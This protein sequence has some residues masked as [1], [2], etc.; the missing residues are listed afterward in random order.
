MWNSF[1]ELSIFYG[2]LK[3]DISMDVIL[4]DSQNNTDLFIEH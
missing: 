4:K 1:L 2:N 3:A